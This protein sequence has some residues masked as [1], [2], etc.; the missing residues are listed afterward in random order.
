MARWDDTCNLK[1]AL[2]TWINEIHG[3]S[4]PPLKCC[5]KLGHGLN[6]DHMGHLLCPAEYDWDDEE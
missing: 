4:N 3:A 2:V 5:S 1:S 6:N